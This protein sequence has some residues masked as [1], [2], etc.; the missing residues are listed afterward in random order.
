MN[1]RHLTNAEWLEILEEAAMHYGLNELAEQ[2]V[3]E[4]RAEAAVR[5][6]AEEHPVQRGWV[7]TTLGHV[8]VRAGERLATAPA[9]PAVMR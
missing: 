1:D 6:Y 2:R 4:L 5:R 3:A 9:R 8:L 7:R